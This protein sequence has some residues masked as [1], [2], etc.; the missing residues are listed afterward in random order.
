MLLVHALHALAHE[1]R[2]VFLV[3]C[4]MYFSG[5]TCL[6]VMLIEALSHRLSS[7]VACVGDEAGQFIT[8]E[9]FFSSLLLKSI[10]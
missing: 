5:Q 6:F 4:T 1:E 3:A 9:L 2:H 7:N 8:D 10:G